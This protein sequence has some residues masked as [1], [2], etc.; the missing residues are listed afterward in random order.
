MATASALRPMSVIVAYIREMYRQMPDPARPLDT[1][2]SE[3]DIKNPV[4][5]RVF[6]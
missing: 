5:D 2:R 1:W 6:R 4:L 3:Q